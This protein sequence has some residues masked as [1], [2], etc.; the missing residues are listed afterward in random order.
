MNGVPSFDSD[1]LLPDGVYNSDDMTFRRTFVEECVGRDLRE[2]IWTGFN[3]LRNEAA[4]H[5]VN[6]LQWVDGSFVTKIP[7]PGDIDLVS[8]VDYDVLNAMDITAQGMVLRLLN[9]RE[10]TKADYRTHTF[11]SPSC[12]AGHHFYVQFEMARQY[13][14][15]WFGQ[16]NPKRPPAPPQ[17][18]GFVQMALGDE[19][20]A[21]KVSADRT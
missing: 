8:F 1:G 2:E 15:K 6:A 13:W 7:D 3:K 10:A 21:P 19:S 17:P 9:A 4:S 16:S 12:T 14:R 18:K 5:G 11:L 20:H